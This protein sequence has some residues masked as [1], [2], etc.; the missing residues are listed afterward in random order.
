MLSGPAL[1]SDPMAAPSRQHRSRATNI[2]DR[3]VDVIDEGLQLAHYTQRLHTILH[4]LA[5]SSSKHARQLDAL[6][7]SICH[8]A[9]SLE[10]RSQQ[11]CASSPGSLERHPCA[12]HNDHTTQNPHPC[13]RLEREASGMTSWG[14]RGP[15]HKRTAG[16]ETTQCTAS[17]EALPKAREV[18]LEHL[19]QPTSLHPAAGLDADGA[20]TAAWP[21][22]AAALAKLYASSADASEP[23]PSGR[24]PHLQLG[25]SAIEGPQHSYRSR[26]SSHVHAVDALELTQAL[27]LMQQREL[28]TKRSWRQG[29]ALASIAGSEKHSLHDSCSSRTLVQ[30]SY[31]SARISRKS[32]D[33]DH[34]RDACSLEGGSHHSKG[35]RLDCRQP[36]GGGNAAGMAQEIKEAAWEQTI[37]SILAGIHDIDLQ[38]RAHKLHRYG[39]TARQSQH[40]SGM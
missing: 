33:T 5:V 40:G 6:P 17:Y 8:P 34:S 19:T 27:T 32:R 7:P 31:P 20:A 21:D 29:N 26:S 2:G 9:P 16:C 13:G 38:L 39:S 18:Q 28:H 11:F 4:A 35:C 10:V 3:L 30:W 14:Q 12:S 22:L 25:A 37:P 15:G 36:Y 24:E 23:T 1:P